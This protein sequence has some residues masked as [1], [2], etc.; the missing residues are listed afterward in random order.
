MD[1]D[2]LLQV[3]KCLNYSICYTAVTIVE[4][5]FPLHY[6]CE[7]FTSEKSHK[8]CGDCERVKVQT[9]CFHVMTVVTISLDCG[10]GVHDFAELPNA[11]RSGCGK[12]IVGVFKQKYSSG[13]MNSTARRIF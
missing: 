7:C 2:P 11:L 5:W 12:Q 1:S 6:N 3:G 8:K 10:K 9:F 4:C 13:K